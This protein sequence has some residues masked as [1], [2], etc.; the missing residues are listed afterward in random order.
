M[1]Y[2][3]YVSL[4]ALLLS[5]IF[6]RKKT[7]KS[8]KIAFKKFIGILP[9]L[10]FMVILMSIA[11]YFITDSTVAR[12]LSGDNIV[13][14][15]IISIAIGSIGMLPGFIVF[16]LCG[17]LLQYNVPYFIISAFSMTMMFVGIIT[18]PIERRYLGT[19]VSL[20]R[21]I[22]GLLIAII[23]AIVTGIIYGELI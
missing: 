23:I 10:L 18:F 4:G 8:L 14:G 9:V 15:F 7:F 5:L 3:I 21:N 11:N 16:P 1:S 22:I 17:Q 6:D 13:M 20:I 2:V 12:L 19:K